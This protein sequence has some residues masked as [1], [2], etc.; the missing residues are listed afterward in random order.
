VGTSNQ[1]AVRFGDN[2]KPINAQVVG[3]DEGSDLA[4][5]KVD[6]SSVKGIRPLAF[7]N[8]DDVKVGDLAVAIGNPLGLPRTATA[9]IVSGL[10]REIQAPDGFQI[11]KV[12][13][14]DAPI[15]PGNSGGPLL[16]E[17]GEVVG[18][19]SQIVATA[20]GAGGN[21]GIGF[22]VPA[23]TVKDIV[24]KLRTGQKIERPYIGV[25]TSPSTS[26]GAT[27]AE[28][29]P[30]SPADRAGLAQ[31]DVIT[32]V[33]GQTVMKPDDIASAISANKPG[34][35]ISIEV[36]RGPSAEDVEVELGQRPANLPGG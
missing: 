5:I 16:N 9:G 15:N 4:V 11:D 6:P 2:G 36:R 24:P 13:Q 28:V 32:K 31:G 19:N 25:S 27:V 20:G 30:G 21:I 7:A 10:K 17:R 3:R 14:T 18:V 1:V 23:N 33:N 22:A 26:G 12:I 8:S 34:D 35:S 29:T